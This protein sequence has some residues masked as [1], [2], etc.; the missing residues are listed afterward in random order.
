M[1][2]SPIVQRNIVKVVQTALKQ[3]PIVSITGPRQSGKT[4]LCHLAA[5]G[6]T[7]LNMEI[8]ENKHFAESDPHGFL[9]Q[10]SHHVILDEVQTVP[11]L[12]PYL[13][14]YTDLRN[15]NGAYILSGSQNFLLMKNISQTLAG[16]VAIF[17]LLP[18]SIK[19]LSPY[20]SKKEKD[21]RY[22]TIRGFYPRLYHDKKMNPSIFYNSYTK[23]YIEHD[24][25]QLVNIQKSRQFSQFLKLC[26]TR[27]GNIFN[28]QEIAA[29]I[30]ID[31]KTVSN[32]ISVLEASYIIYML[33]AYYNNF[34]KRIIKKPKLYFYDT[35]L[36]C[37]L[38][39]IKTSTQL[40]GQLSGALFENLVIME[41][42]KNKL[43]NGIHPSMYFWQDS[44]GNEVDLII[45]QD[46][47]LELYEI[48]SGESFKPDFLKNMNLFSNILEKHGLKSKKQLIYN[49]NQSFTMH[50]TKVSTFAEL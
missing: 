45:E 36:L 32:W 3:Y 7:Y 20:L 21:W 34:E 4:T 31:N 16:R 37:N 13:Q 28:A 48:K 14:Y 47:K 22:M 30:G 24:V 12:F 18:F 35:G 2:K 25:K 44:N 38:L 10:Y 33:P 40:N 50:G 29:S 11:T 19:E 5:S 26:A 23:T 43:Y 46:A 6:Y 9:K 49:G 27:A 15:K 8:M 39:N 42:M 1:S 41:L 17:S